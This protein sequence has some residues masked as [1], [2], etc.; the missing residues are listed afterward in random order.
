MSKAKKPKPEEVLLAIASENEL[1]QTTDGIPVIVIDTGGKRRTVILPDKEYE[2]FLAKRLYDRTGMI[3][4]G[5]WIRDAMRVVEA[6]CLEGPKRPVFTRV[7]FY[8]NVLYIDLGDDSL[9]VIKVTAEGWSIESGCPILFH[10]SP[11]V[12]PM[13]EPVRGGTLAELRPLLNI[14]DGDWP[15]VVAF[16]LACLN[17]HGPFPLLILIGQSGATKTTVARLIQGIIDS[18]FDIQRNKE[19]VFCPPKTIEDLMVFALHSWLLSFDN[20]TAISD[21]MSEALCRLSTGGTTIARRLYTN[22][23]L[24]KMRAQQPVILT[25]INDCI[26]AEDL[27]SRSLFLSLEMV[28]PEKVIGEA[29]LQQQYI[30]MR[31]RVMGALLDC[32]V[33]ALA[34]FERTSPMPGNRLADMTRW[35]LAAEPATGLPPGTFA[36]ALGENRQQAAEEALCSPLAE[37]IRKLASEGVRLKPEEIRERLLAI[38]VPDVPNAV[39]LG[40]K[41]KNMA[42]E[43][44]AVG[45][46]VKKEGRQWRI[47]RLAA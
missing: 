27:R 14:R 24:S 15:I 7:G 1:C 46:L 23:G 8:D 16:M 12:S 20:I 37:G 18:T 29:T 9:R 25:G 33:C 3:P 2:A 5:P 39:S 40:W 4:K 32:I 17:P 43:M 19:E 36:Q 38:D 30:E 44:A 41:L 47:E 21:A 42:T 10:R 35:L 34:N 11:N 45:I 6:I 28:D 22:C 31:P 26:K 13:P